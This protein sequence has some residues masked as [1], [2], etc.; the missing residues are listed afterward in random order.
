MPRQVFRSS[1][2]IYVFIRVQGTSN[3]ME[4]MDEEFTPVDVDVNLVKSL[5]DSYSSQQGQPG[6]TSN[7]LGLMGLQLPQDTT[8]GKWSRYIFSPHLI[9]LVQWVSWFCEVTHLHYL[10]STELLD[11]EFPHVTYILW[12]I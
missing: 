5:L 10:V 2:E 3:T 6:P 8:K 1:Y 4:G 12:T 7:L 11:A 9:F